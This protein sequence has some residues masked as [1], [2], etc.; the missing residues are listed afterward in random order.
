MV[1]SIKAEKID[2]N[3][4]NL[5]IKTF[6]KLR[7]GGDYVNIN[8]PYMKTHTTLSKQRFTF[9]FHEQEKI[10]RNSLNIGSETQMKNLR[11]NL[12]TQPSL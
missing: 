8:K 2:K 10:F 9:S 4:P 5:M 7:V 11:T 1:I 6:N 3:E 12:E